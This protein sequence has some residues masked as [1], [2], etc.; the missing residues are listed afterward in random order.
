MP[1]LFPH[2]TG[3]RR[4]EP[5]RLWCFTAF[6]QPGV[7]KRACC[8]TRAAK[9]PR[10]QVHDSN[11]GRRG[12][13][14]D[15]QRPERER[16]ILMRLQNGDVSKTSLKRCQPALPACTCATYSPH[17]GTA[18]ES[19]PAEH[20]HRTRTLNPACTHADPLLSSPGPTGRTGNVALSNSGVVFSCVHRC[21]CAAPRAFVQSRFAGFASGSLAAVSLPLGTVYFQPGPSPE[22]EGLA[23]CE[24]RSAESRK[25]TAGSGI[26]V[27]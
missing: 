11:H 6:S 25:N 3:R 14:C 15:P 12:L 26:H 1:R 22:P 4:R 23:D 2:M 16:G 18:S 20:T 10:D 19:P 7:N 9:G 13:S 17:L 21:V 24:T 27:R 8:M 5:L